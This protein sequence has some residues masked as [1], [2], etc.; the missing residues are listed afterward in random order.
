MAAADISQAV[1][2]AAE[3]LAPDTSICPFCGEEL[4]EVKRFDRQLLGWLHVWRVYVCTVC[5][6]R[7][8]V[9]VPAINLATGERAGG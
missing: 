2:E 9:E 5:G 8:Q 1:R 6:V 7:V 3:R 4:G